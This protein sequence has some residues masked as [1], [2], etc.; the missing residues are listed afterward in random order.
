M[1]RSGAE[2][3]YTPSASSTTM[4]PDIAP[5][6]RPH[7]GLRGGQRARLAGGAG[8]AGAGGRGVEGGGGREGRGRRGGH[9]DHG[10]HRCR[11]GAGQHQS[12]HRGVRGFKHGTSLYGG[13]G[14]VGEMSHR[15]WSG[16][17]GSRPRAAVASSA[18]RAHGPGGHARGAVV[19]V[20]MACW[21][22]G[23]GRHVKA[24]LP[25]EGIPRREA[26]LSPARDPEGVSEVWKGDQL[27]VQRWL[28]PPLQDQM[29]SLVPLARGA[30]GTSRH[31]PRRRR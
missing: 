4:S 21:S 10:G 29:T 17:C 13:W 26:I 24:A 11:G 7:R 12:P 27:R 15:S 20:R 16:G 28:A 19:Q 14:V 18:R 25:W 6:H 1:N 5:L 9:R 22:P 2:S 8:G 3:R 30:V 23:A 31:S